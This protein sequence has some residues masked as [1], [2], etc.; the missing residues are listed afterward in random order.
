MTARPATAVPRSPGPSSL[1][2]SAAMRGNTKKNT[3]P[4]MAVR[5]RLHRLGYRFR[6]HVADLPG[7]PDIVLSRHRT[8]IQVRGCFWHQHADPGCPLRAKPRSNTQ[9]WEPKLQRNVERD[10]EQD[11]ALESLGWRVI[12]VWECQCQGEH[13][14]AAALDVIFR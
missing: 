2:V 9:Y 13:Q 8:V 14:L 6:L 3:R 7:R 5:K 11:A 12:T 4:E 10:A 1:A